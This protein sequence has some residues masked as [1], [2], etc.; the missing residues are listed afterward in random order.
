MANIII[1][2]EAAL[3]MN[4]SVGTQNVRCYVPKGELPVDHNMSDIIAELNFMFGLVS[5]GMVKL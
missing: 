3:H 5:V 4:G 2:N 1:G